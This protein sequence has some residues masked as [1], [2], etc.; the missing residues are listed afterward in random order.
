M[1]ALSEFLVRARTIAQVEHELTYKAGHRDE[2]YGERE[3]RWTRCN[4][5]KHS[6]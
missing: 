4:N 5:H 6:K 1:R 2:L 3:D